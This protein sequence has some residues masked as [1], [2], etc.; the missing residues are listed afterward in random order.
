MRAPH[1]DNVSYSILNPSPRH[2]QTSHAPRFRPLIWT[3]PSYCHTTAAHS[4]ACHN[5]A[6]PGSESHAP[7]TG[8]HLEIR[9]LV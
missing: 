2:E 9:M 6:N 5:G 7:A 3:Q 4:H 8:A 1:Y